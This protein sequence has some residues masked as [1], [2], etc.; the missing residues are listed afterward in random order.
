M[1]FDAMRKFL[2]RSI[3]GRVKVYKIEDFNIEPPEI[4]KLKKSVEVT[5]YKPKI[6]ISVSKPFDFDKEIKCSAKNFNFSNYSSVKVNKYKI[7]QYTKHDIKIQKF[8]LNKKLRIWKPLKQIQALP[9]E[10]KNMLKFQKKRPNVAVNEAILAWYWPI[11]DK[12]VI[13]LVLDK[14]R[15]TLLVCTVRQ[16][17][18]IKQEEYI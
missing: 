11:V 16:A 4:K 2:A 18:S 9:Q 6:K 8:S 10:R 14:Q 7:K 17:D 12:A 3:T 15:G 1:A 13:K 5:H